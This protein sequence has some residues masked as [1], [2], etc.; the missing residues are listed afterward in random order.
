[1]PGPGHPMRGPRGA[2]PKIENPGKLL[3]RLMGIVFK[4]YTP[5]VIIVIIGIF[6]GVFANIQGTLCKH[7]DID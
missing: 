1:M 6:V 7:T 4:N 3:K 5:H 2:K